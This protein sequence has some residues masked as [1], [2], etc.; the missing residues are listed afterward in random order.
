MKRGFGVL[1]ISLLLVLPIVSAGFFDWVKEKVQLGPQETQDVAVTV[2]NAVP[3][4][5]VMGSTGISSVII[6]DSTGTATIIFQ[7]SDANGQGEVDMS[8]APEAIDITITSPSL[9]TRTADE[10]GC[11]TTA[12]PVTNGYEYTCDIIMS[13]YEEEGTWDVDVSVTDSNSGVG[14][15]DDI[16]EDTDDLAVSQLKAIK[17]LRSILGTA[18]AIEFGTVTPDQTNIDSTAGIEADDTQVVNTGNFII[19]DAVGATDLTIQSVALSNGIDN[20]PATN[21]RSADQTDFAEVCSGP[22]GIT[23]TGAEVSLTNF[24]LDKGSQATPVS[25]RDVRHCLTLVPT[26]ISSGVYNTGGTGW[27]F[28]I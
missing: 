8:G 25:S 16:A 27:T 7:V 28:R 4:V 19:D 3:I 26:G 12:T 20:I 18:G 6:E 11:L 5:D 23:H 9:E 17:L 1:M 14:T 10:G 2:G 22:G 13:F 21:F 15:A 24:D